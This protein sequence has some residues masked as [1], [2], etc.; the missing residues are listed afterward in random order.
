MDLWRDPNAQN[1]CQF[2]IDIQFDIYHILGKMYF[3][4]FEGYVLMEID[5]ETK[6]RGHLSIGGQAWTLDDVW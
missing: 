1:R 3:G 4:L 5:L 6:I 2:H